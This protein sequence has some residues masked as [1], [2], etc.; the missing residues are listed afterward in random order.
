MSS[1]LAVVDQSTTTP[2]TLQPLQTVDVEAAEAFMN[3]YQEL[4]EALLDDT[5]YQDIYTNEG[6]KKS[7]KKSAWRKLATAFNIS[8]DV[9]EKEIIRDECQ[10]II[11]AR[12]EVIA[13]LPNG[14]HGVG[15]GSASIFDKI[16]KD[17]VKEPTPFELRKRYTNAEHD[18]ISTA[19]TRAKSRAIA[20]LIGAG[21][22][23]AEELEN[24]V[25]KPSARPKSQPKVNKPKSHSLDNTSTLGHKPKSP[26]AKSP[27]APKAP[28]KPKEDKAVEVE[29]E[30]H[31]MSSDKP[32]MSLKEIIDSNPNIRAAV[33]E[34]QAQGT[35]ANRDNI[36]A[37]LLD[38]N[39]MGKIT[40]D[41]YKTC[42]ELLE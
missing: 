42:K 3:N 5:D 11:S 25:N 18:I 36:K 40:T 13:T 27:K 15:T 33:D 23:S 35:T 37:K 7:K 31:D 30:V 29:Y 12:Y 38:F 4:V 1:D 17:D 32:A 10:R 24:M 20:D 28:S 14:R 8:D 34:L 39:E 21:E 22:V 26:K 19:H 9:V 6:I 2:T 16:K 41:D